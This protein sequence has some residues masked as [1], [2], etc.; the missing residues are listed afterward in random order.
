L[1]GDWGNLSDDDKAVNDAALQNGSRLLSAY[2]AGDGTA[3][4]VI[5]EP[6][7]SMTTVILPADY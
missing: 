6:D 4:W 5:T 1:N 3:F 7:R 2:E